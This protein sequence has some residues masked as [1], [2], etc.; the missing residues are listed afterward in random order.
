MLVHGLYQLSLAQRIGRHRPALRYVELCQR[1]ASP[2]GHAIKGRRL[3]G[4]Q[5]K[6]VGAVRKRMQPP[7]LGY[8][9]PC[10]LKALSA[11][12]RA[13]HMLIGHDGRQ[14]RREEV[15]DHRRV[16]RPRSRPTSHAATCGVAHRRDWRV[17]AGIGAASRWRAVAELQPPSERAPLSAVLV[18]R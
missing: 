8:A 12:A 11:R 10:E 3:V 4:M 13:E 2:S 15:L 6:A 16:E 17:V 7:S 5:P 1:Q 9:M 18:A 14:Q